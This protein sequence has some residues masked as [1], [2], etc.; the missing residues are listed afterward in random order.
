MQHQVVVSRNIHSIGYDAP[1]AVLEV[2][3]KNHSTYQYDGVPAEVHAAL[4]SAS[5]HGTYLNA[6]IK[7][8]YPYRRIS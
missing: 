3:F 4:L 5:S 6:R 2:T 7:G 1:S 8:R